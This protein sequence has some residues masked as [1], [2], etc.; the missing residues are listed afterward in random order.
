MITNKKIFAFSEQITVMANGT[1]RLWDDDCVQ[2]LPLRKYV[3]EKWLKIATNSQLAERW[4]KDSNECT[5]TSK[6][7]KMANIYAII[8]SRTVMYF[9][10]DCRREYIDHI[11]KATKFFTQGKLGERTDKRTGLVEIVNEKR[12]DEMRG[13]MLVEK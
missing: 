10:D 12:R 3:Q 5:A 1:G 6:D 4:V 9:N 8:R 11:R 13:S 7:E 2:M